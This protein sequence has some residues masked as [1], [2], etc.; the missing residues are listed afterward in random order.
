MRKIT[1]EQATTLAREYAGGTAS[2]VLADR[3]GVGAKTV[4]Y[5]LHRLGVPLRDRDHC[6]RRY[7]LN[8]GAFDTLT[9]ETAYWIGFLLADGCVVRPA[10][11]APVLSLNLSAVD[12]EHVERF[13]SFLGSAHPIKEAPGHGFATAPMVQ[14][15]IPSRRLAAS[16]ASYGV[17]PRKSKI[18]SAS[19]VLCENRHFWRGVV[20]GDGWVSVRR[21]NKYRYLGVGL[22]G[23]PQLVAQFA[24]FC[25]AHSTTRASVRED[26][27]T[28][29]FCLLG[30]AASAMLSILYTDASVAL[31]RKAELAKRWAS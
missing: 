11:G 4:R 3:L 7:V 20:D 14:L 18:A 24:A 29:K 16:L 12:R 28:A 27:G 2:T 30:S 13:R 26:R 25:R 10:R 5:H 31:V 15:L 6:N 21:F 22:V 8:E 23:S 19:D 1:D 9:E 17:V